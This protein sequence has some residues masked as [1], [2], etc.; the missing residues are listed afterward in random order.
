MVCAWQVV[1]EQE[2][3]DALAGDA[4]ADEGPD[5]LPAAHKRRVIKKL[6]QDDPAFRS[7]AHLNSSGNRKLLVRAS[8]PF[9]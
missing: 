8:P 3:R 9:F 1:E 5:V 6:A 2:F 4:L 7:F